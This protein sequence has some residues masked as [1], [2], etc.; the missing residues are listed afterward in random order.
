MPTIGF[1]AED[2]TLGELELRMILPHRCRLTNVRLQRHFH[3]G[4]PRNAGGFWNTLPEKMKVTR[5]FAV[6]RQYRGRD[7]RQSVGLQRGDHFRDRVLRF[8]S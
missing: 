8:T 4:A 7:R 6:N 3:D 1:L 2:L 5:T